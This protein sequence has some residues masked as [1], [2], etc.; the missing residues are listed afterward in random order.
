MISWKG[1]TTNHTRNREKIKSESQLDQ[2][3]R[4]TKVHNMLLDEVIG[5]SDYKELIRPEHTWSKRKNG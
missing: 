4:K 1:F 3:D 5:I 2:E